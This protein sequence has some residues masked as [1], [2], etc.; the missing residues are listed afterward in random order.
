MKIIGREGVDFMREDWD[1]LILLDSCRYDYFKQENFIEGELQY[2]FSLGRNSMEFMKKNFSN[3][4]LYD[5]VYVTSNP[6]IERLDNENFHD[7]IKTPL[8]NGWK[9]KKGTSPPEAVT[10]A[11]IEAN[12]Q[13]PHKRLVIH[14]MQPH[15]PYLGETAKEIYPEDRESG[16]TP[17]NKDSEHRWRV[18]D[19]YNN[20]EITNK[21]LQKM[22]IETLNIALEEVVRLLSE[23]NGKSVISSDHGEFLGDRP[24]ILWPVEMF[25]HGIGRRY[26]RC[27][28]LCKVPWLMVNQ[29][30]NRKQIVSEEPVLDSES[31]NSNTIKDRLDSLGY[32]A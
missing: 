22:Y 5:T 15:V 29:G 2:R 21:S 8:T 16:W 3:K 17:V 18:G 14:Y 6:H 32:S 25:G 31:L 13:Y 24:H 28:E 10:N 1:N 7:V 20:D 9:E 4:E 26:P 30:T 27:N 19:V 23:M 12:Q 11:A